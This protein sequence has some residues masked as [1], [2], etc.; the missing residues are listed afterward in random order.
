MLLSSLP[1]FAASST[2]AYVGTYTGAQSR[3]IYAYRVEEVTGSAPRFTPL[4]LAVEAVNPSFLAID[5]SRRL[6][7][8]STKR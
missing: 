1:V 2:I 3:G 4:G 8:I 6:V 7:D 5:A